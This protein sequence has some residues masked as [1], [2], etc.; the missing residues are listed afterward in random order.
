M[1]LGPVKKKAE[2][3]SEQRRRREDGK[4]SREERKAERQEA[5]APAQATKPEIDVE[6]VESSGYPATRKK[7]SAKPTPASE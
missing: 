6:E 5:P 1:V 2:A 4:P 3:K 7:T